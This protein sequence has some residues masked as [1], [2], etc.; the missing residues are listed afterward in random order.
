M[1]NARPV[2]AVTARDTGPRSTFQPNHS[3]TTTHATSMAINASTKATIT[4]I[5]RTMPWLQL[6]GWYGACVVRAAARRKVRG[7]TQQPG[8][9]KAVRD[10]R[11]G[12]SPVFAAPRYDPFPL[13]LAHRAVILVA[14]PCGPGGASAP[15]RD[16]LLTVNTPPRWL[17]MAREQPD[18]FVNEC[19]VAFGRLLFSW[20]SVYFWQ[21]MNMPH[22]SKPFCHLDLQLG[23]K[24]IR[25]IQR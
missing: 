24:S 10:L 14:P 25:V 1:E 7:S 16:G 22:P 12:A 6:P 2:L 8:P 21:L 5:H 23:R 15:R 4:F 19:P 13:G 18:V 9:D 17:S 20:K 3:S 11:V